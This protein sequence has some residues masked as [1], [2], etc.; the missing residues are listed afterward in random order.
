[1]P[2]SDAQHRVLAMFDAAQAVSEELFSLIGKNNPQFVEEIADSYSRRGKILQEIDNWR[3]AHADEFADE[4]FQARWQERAH[5][6]EECDAQLL[7]DLPALRRQ[8]HDQLV[9]LNKRKYLLL[10]S[11]GQST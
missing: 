3:R 9:D 1:M 6:L 11:R 5:K 10:Y 8:V 2:K 4:G 7:R